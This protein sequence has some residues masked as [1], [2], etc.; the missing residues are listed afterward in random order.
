MARRFP[1]RRPTSCR[2]TALYTFTFDPG[3]LTLSGTFV[4]RDGTFDD[5]FNRQYTFQPASTQVNVRAT[6]T[7]ANNRYNIILFCNNLFDT[8]A[9]DGAA[10]V[11]LQ[12]Q[13]GNE[14]ILRAPFLN[15][16]RTFG[17]QFQYRWR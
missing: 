9:Y 13:P 6:W 3:K 7:D 2:S 4:W 10:G 14:T 15:A 12:N 16:P 1:A 8:T 5:V 11:L 17:I